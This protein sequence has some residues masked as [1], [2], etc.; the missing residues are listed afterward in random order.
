MSDRSLDEQ[1]QEADDARVDRFVEARFRLEPER[2]TDA[3]EPDP[4][5]EDEMFER[6]MRQYFPRVGGGP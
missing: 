3:G 6:V 1:Q 4:D 2:T 5:N